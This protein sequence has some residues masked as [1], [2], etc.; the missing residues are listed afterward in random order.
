MFLQLCL[1]IFAF[2]IPKWKKTLNIFSFSCFIFYFY[3]LVSLEFIL[4]ILWLIVFS[5]DDWN[6]LSHSICSSVVWL[7]CQEVESIS[8]SPWIWVSP[9]LLWPIIYSRSDAVP[10]VGMSLTS[11]KAAS[12]CLLEV[13]L[14]LWEAPAICT[15]HVSVL[16]LTVSM[17]VSH[18]RCPSTSPFRWLQL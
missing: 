5:S 1:F 17:W 7:P 4:C 13:S 6:H 14:T 11:L 18:L 12:F 15:G 9:R 2:C 10:V 8:L 3:Y 16:P